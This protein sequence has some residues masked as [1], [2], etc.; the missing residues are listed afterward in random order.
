MNTYRRPLGLN[1]VA[2]L[3][4][5]T[6]KTVELYTEVLGFELVGHALDDKVGSTG[7]PQRFLHTFFAMEDGSC[8][9]FFELEG[10]AEG[11]DQTVVP[12]WVRHIALSVDSMEALEEARQ[13]VVAAGLDVIGP[14]DHEG[15]WQSIYFFDH[16]GIRLELTYQCRPLGEADAAAAAD[17]VAGWVASR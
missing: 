9:A 17:A 7:E 2:Y 8:I 13:R 1:H 15:I 3:T 10:L 12:P 11:E 16:N 4:R 14:V 6:A 5:D